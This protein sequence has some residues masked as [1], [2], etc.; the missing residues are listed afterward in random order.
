[1]MSAL[2]AAAT[3]FVLRHTDVVPTGESPATAESLLLEAYGVSRTPRCPRK[4][5]A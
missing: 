5:P 2:A 3:L 4:A 1:M